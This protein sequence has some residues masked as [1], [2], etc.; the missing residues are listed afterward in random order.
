MRSSQT[1]RRRTLP[2][3]LT[4]VLL[5]AAALLVPALPAAAHDELIGTDPA[6]D[7]V[8][9]TL[10]EQITLSYSADVLTDAGATVIE[11]TDAAGTSLTDGVPEVSGSEVTQALAGPASGTVTVQWRVVSSDG[12]PIDGEFA[13]SVPESTPTPTPSATP[14]ASATAAAS[15]GASPAATTEVTIPLESDAPASPLPWILLV[16]ALVIVAGALVYVFASRGPRNTAGGGG[17][18][19]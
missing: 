13:F 17:A 15:E 6:S 1:P 9:E 18:G 3:V 12:H 4:T 11:V 7:A 5:A 19:R 2:A 8:L 16:V 14:S 10:P